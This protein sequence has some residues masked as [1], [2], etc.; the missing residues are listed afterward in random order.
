MA[1]GDRV[2]PNQDFLHQ[3]SQDLLPH[4]YIHHLCAYPQFAAKTRQALG[5]LQVSRSINRCH[6]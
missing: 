4:R 2:D 6:L 3:Q 1:Q 5:Q